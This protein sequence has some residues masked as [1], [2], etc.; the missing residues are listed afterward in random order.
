MLNWIDRLPWKWLLLLAV[1]MA[2]APIT[3]EP[4]LIEKLRM[5][6]A[7]TLVRPLDIFDLLMHAAPLVVVGIKVGRRRSRT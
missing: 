1:W 4:H 5:L 2:I 7:G 3:P 6:A